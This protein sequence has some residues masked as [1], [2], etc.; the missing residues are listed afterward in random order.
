MAAA[1]G[2][3]QAG[4]VAA[5]S[6]AGTLYALLLSSGGRIQTYQWVPTVG[7]IPGH[8]NQLAPDLNV[9][10]GTASAQ[11]LAIDPATSYPVVA[12]SEATG[13]LPGYVKRYDPVAGWTLLTGA[14]ALPVVSGLAVGPA[15][16]PGSGGVVAVSQVQS[17]G[18]NTLIRV[19]RY[20]R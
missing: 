14:S 11:R 7:L 10:A 9:G 20:N 6:S 4:S 13:G 8:W 15:V 1:F 16:A 19:Q 5:T 3:S 12:W 17:V 18:Y 2:A